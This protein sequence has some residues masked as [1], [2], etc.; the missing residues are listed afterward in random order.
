[1]M[2]PT[3]TVNYDENIELGDVEKKEGAIINCGSGVNCKHLLHEI[4]KNDLAALGPNPDHNSPLYKGYLEAHHQK[5][6]LRGIK[7]DCDL[8]HADLARDKTKFHHTLVMLI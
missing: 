3:S 8:Y 2:E 6:C 4:Q 7:A 5:R 1:M